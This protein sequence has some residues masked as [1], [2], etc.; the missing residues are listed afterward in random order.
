[1]SVYSLK[2]GKP[3]PKEAM[4]KGIRLT[5]D[6]KETEPQRHEMTYQKFHRGY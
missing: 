2:M 3:L 1:M 6:R 4:I 5:K